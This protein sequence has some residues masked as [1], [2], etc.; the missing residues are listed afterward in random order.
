MAPLIVFILIVLV[1]VVR[2]RR[3]GWGLGPFLCMEAVYLYVRLWHGCRCR[4]WPLPRG[5]PA[6]VVANHTCSADAAL[7]TAICPRPPCFLIAGPY[8]A[9]ALLR[10]FF[11]SIHA[12]PVMRDGGDV[13]AVRLAL[14]RLQEGHI[15]VI[16]PEG[17]LSNAGRSRPRRGKAGVALLALLSG[18][19]VV[20][21]C[22][23]GGP[24]TNQVLRAWLRPSRA[25]VV[26]GRPVDL[27]GYRTRPRNRQVLEEVTQLILDRI[28]Q[29]NVSSKEGLRWCKHK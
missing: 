18:A 1:L 24:Q 11:E 13:T 17:G 27:S 4:G 6:I 5:G 14:R 9:N 21:V 25:Q 8:Y 16:F 26:C 22:I 23:Q 20:P 29:L 15:L 19:P 2:W 10:R 3:S 7:V 28:A 12:V